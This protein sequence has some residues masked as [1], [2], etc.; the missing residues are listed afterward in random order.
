MLNHIKDYYRKQKVLIFGYRNR[1]EKTS[2]L[3]SIVMSKD[4]IPHTPFTYLLKSWVEK[5]IFWR[6]FKQISIFYRRKSHH[7]SVQIMTFFFSICFKIVQTL[8]NSFIML[9]CM[10]WEFMIINSVLILIRIFLFA[11]RML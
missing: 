9:L 6:F 7:T 3:L 11:M 2:F 1:E 8:C 10:A 5:I 4:S